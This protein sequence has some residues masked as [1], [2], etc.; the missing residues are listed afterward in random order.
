MAFAMV[1]KNGDG[2]ITPRELMTVMTGLG[3]KSD[4]VL[5]KQMI[6]CFDADGICYC[7]LIVGTVLLFVGVFVSLAVDLMCVC[8]LYRLLVGCHSSLAVL[9]CFFGCS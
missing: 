4:D 7:C 8:T 6:A 1:D 3:F 9:K 2:R 5:V